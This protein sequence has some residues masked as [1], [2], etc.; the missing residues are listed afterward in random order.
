MRHRLDSRRN[1]CLRKIRQNGLTHLIDRHSIY[2]TNKGHEIL[3]VLSAA[4]PSRFVPYDRHERQGLLV[5][6]DCR[7]LPVTQRQYFFRMI[8]SCGPFQFNGQPAKEFN[9]LFEKIR[10][11]LNTDYVFKKDYMEALMILIIHLM[12][13]NFNPPLVNQK[14]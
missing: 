5:L 12:I 3:I 2:F 9:W 4:A 14:Q 8:H 7:I 13:K 11:E 10:Q 1:I 6:F